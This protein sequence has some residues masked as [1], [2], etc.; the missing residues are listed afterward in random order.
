MTLFLDSASSKFTDVYDTFF[1]QDVKDVEYL[2]SIA[3]EIKSNLPET[4]NSILFIEQNCN[5]SEWIIYNY[6]MMDKV[7]KS[8]WR[9]FRLT[10]E[11]KY[12]G[13]IWSLVVT[14]EA[15][16]NTVEEFDYIFIDISDEYFDDD[17]GSLFDVNPEEGNLYHVIKDGSDVKINYECSISQKYK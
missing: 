14:Q 6:F 4:N 9:S 3:E 10:E 12:E 1:T 17:F 16:M 8:K 13:D 7:R 15:F 2:Q 5:G 11:E